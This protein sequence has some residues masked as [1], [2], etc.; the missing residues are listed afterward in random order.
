MEIK[1]FQE[2]VLAVFSEIAKA[3][4]R[5]PHTKQS[6]MIHLTEEIG[7]VARQINNE[8]HRPEKFNKENLGEELADL[9]MFIVFIANLY[10]INLPKKMRDSIEKVKSATIKLKKQV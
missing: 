1:K 10:D 5:R 6:A 8:S 7:E 9:M 4:N 3:P 2:E